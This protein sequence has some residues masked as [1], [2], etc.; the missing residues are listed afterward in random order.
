MQTRENMKARENGFTLVELMVV[1]LIIAVLIAIAIPTFLGARTRAQDR[2]AQSDLRNTLT[3][4]KVFY[5]DESADYGFTAAQIEN[6]NTAIIPVP[7]VTPPTGIVGF[8]AH[9]NQDGLPDQALQLVIESES[10]TW[11]C[12]WDEGSGTEAGTYF[13]QDLASAPATWADCSN[14]W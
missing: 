1:I 14:G 7:G 4:A 3:A 12:L 9:P 10:G 2:A 13:G 8:V 5:S 11:Y 6:I